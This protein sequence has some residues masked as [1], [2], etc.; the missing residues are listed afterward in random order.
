[1]APREEA[2]AGKPSAL[3][4]GHPAVDRGGKNGAAEGRG[5]TRCCL[6]PSVQPPSNRPGPVQ[7]V[8]TQKNHILVG[9]VQPSNQVVAPLLYIFSFLSL[10][11]LSLHRSLFS[12]ARGEGIRLDGW[13]DL[14]FYWFFCFGPVRTVPA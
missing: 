13:T 7:P 10:S 6:S 8:L 9:P 1:M 4:Q 5:E 12:R 14:Y 2:R 3:P 11:H